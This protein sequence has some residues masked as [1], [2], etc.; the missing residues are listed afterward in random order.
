MSQQRLTIE[1]IMVR[2]M[3]LTYVA[4]LFGALY[5]VGPVLGWLLVLRM[6]RDGGLREVP[7]SAWVWVAGMV[8]MLVPLIAAHADFDLGLMPMIK[9]A[10]G[11]AKGWALIG[12]FIVLGCAKIRLQE[13]ARAANLLGIQ[14]LCLLPVLVLAW[15]AG[16]PGHLYVSPV[17]VVGGPGPEYFAVELYGRSPDSGAP[18]WRLFAPWAPAIGLVMSTLLPIGWN[19][20]DRRRRLLGAA[21]MLLA[22]LLSGSRLGLLALPGALAFVWVIQQVRKPGFW[23]ACAPIALGASV[24][25]GQLSELAD[26]AVER[27]HGARAASSRVRATLGRIAVDR[28]QSEAPWWGHGNVERGPHIVEYMPIGS[29]HSW[30]G[31]LF[32]KGIVGLLA[33]ALPILWSLWSLVRAPQSIPEV[34]TALTILFLLGLYTFAE[35]LEILAYLTW[36]AYVALGMGLRACAHAH[37]TSNRC[38]SGATAS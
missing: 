10:I 28:W 36:P 12:I 33:L 22:I 26:A 15:A 13:L 2:T 27:F 20:K 29:H 16:A 34:R 21:G 4:Y 3:L 38:L 19:D 35:N 14:T 32:V 5:V 23:W 30:F 7:V 18:R 25:A 24:L 37:I 11:W 9:S 1:Q 6:A 8:V 17:S 31:L